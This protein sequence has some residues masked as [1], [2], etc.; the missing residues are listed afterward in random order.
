MLRFSGVPANRNHRVTLSFLFEAS[1]QQ[2]VLLV[3]KFYNNKRPCM[4]LFWEEGG[5]RA[6][7]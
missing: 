4:Y 7:S 2:S 3:W 1:G 6:Q 5:S